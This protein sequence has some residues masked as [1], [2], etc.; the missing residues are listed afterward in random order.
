MNAP[1]SYFERRTRENR[2]P[3]AVLAAILSILAHFLL[4]NLVWDR[5]WTV[6]TGAGAELMPF[7]VERVTFNSQSLDSPQDLDSISDSNRR[8]DLDSVIEPESA[9]LPETPIP[10]T[11]DFSD[12]LVVDDALE[13]PRPGVDEIPVPESLTDSMSPGADSPLNSMREFLN[14]SPVSDNQPSMTID[15]SVFEAALNG[16]NSASDELARTSESS[17]IPAGFADIDEIISSPGQ[18]F[19]PNRPIL[20]KTDL[21]FEFNQSTLKADARSSLMKLAMLIEQNEDTNFVIEGHTDTFGGV[22]YNLHLSKRRAEAV[23]N[24]LVNSLLLEDER[25]TI[26]AFGKTRPLVNPK[27]NIKEQALNRRVEISMHKKK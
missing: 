14:R 3:W 11:P 27:G 25:I 17:D 20:M 15:K 1:S 6:A 13:S 21:L 23:K 16:E 10:E 5:E 8:N 26:R 9:A 22:Q 19:D 18:G 12:A 2:V 4:L 7:T 24:W